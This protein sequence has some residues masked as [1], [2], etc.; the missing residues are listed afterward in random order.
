[1]SKHR[2]K[3]RDREANNMRRPQGAM[4]NNFPFGINPQQLL[5]MLG[6]NMDMGRLGNILS[7]MNRE[8]FDLNSL[9]GNN[10]GFNLNNM[11]NAM[12]NNNNNNGFNNNYQNNK[13]N[14]STFNNAFDDEISKHK[15]QDSKKNDVEL[16]MDEI[17][18]DI[19]DDDNLQML[20]SLKNIVD[21]SK[22]EFID[23]IIELYESGELK[24]N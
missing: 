2:H 21:P 20:K 5:A 22:Y 9:N 11:M 8:G 12:N 14:N 16:D 1:M 19:D 10:Q 7:S 24:D 23:K 15:K 18:D 13:Q 3:D 6:G 17:N 4:N